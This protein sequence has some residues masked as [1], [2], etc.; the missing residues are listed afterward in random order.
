[1]FTKQIYKPIVTIR[2]QSTKTCSIRFVLNIGIGP[3]LLRE[4]V[5]SND[6][7]SAV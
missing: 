1:M 2:V 6:W 7:L 3:D 5:L 4:D